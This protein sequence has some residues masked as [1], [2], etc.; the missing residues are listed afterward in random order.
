MSER[1]NVQNDKIVIFQFPKRIDLGDY[2]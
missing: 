1:R 2:M